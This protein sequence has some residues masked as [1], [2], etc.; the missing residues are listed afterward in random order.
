MRDASA[1]QHFEPVHAA[2]TDADAVH[3]QRLGDDDVV[4]PH[5][6]ETP[7]L[8]EP[9]DAGKPAA[10]FIHGAADFNRAIELDAGAPDAFDRK[11]RRGNSG[12]HV[13]RSSAVDPAVDD[14]T[15]EW[16]ARPA[17]AG[18]H[19]VEMPVQVHDR[20]RRASMPGPDD[21]D[22]RVALRV[23]GKAFG[24]EVLDLESATLQA[25]SNEVRAVVVRL[26]GRI[27]RRDADE[28]GGERDSLRRRRIDLSKDAVDLCGAHSED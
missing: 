15:A 4:G 19:D 28:I 5:G 7:V 14:V 2:V 3:V 23:L 8:G 17:F 24:R 11:E 20:V 25:I 21:V 6:A 26:T 27:Y 9:G 13:A 1:R 18:R 10:L 22:A 16:I 12:L